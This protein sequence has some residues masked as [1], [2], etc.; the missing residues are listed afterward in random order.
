MH[1]DKTWESSGNSGVWR[2]NWLDAFSRIAGFIR[3][4]YAVG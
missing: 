2:K 3:R 4:P 1:E